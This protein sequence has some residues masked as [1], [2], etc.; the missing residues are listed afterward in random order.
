MKMKGLLIYLLQIIFYVS[1][2]TVVYTKVSTTYKLYGD[3]SLNSTDDEDFDGYDAKSYF[4][5]E[6]INNPLNEDMENGEEY[7]GYF[8]NRITNF[9]NDYYSNNDMDSKDNGWYH[10]GY[11]NEKPYGRNVD[12]YHTSIRINGHYQNSYFDKQ[13]DNLLNN[14]DAMSENDDEYDKQYNALPD[15]HVD[16]SH[17]ENFDDHYNNWPNNDY[18]EGRNNYHYPNY[19]YENN[20][21]HWHEENIGYGPYSHT[22]GNEYANED[23]GRDSYSDY[24]SNLYGKY[25]ANRGYDDNGNYHGVHRNDDHYNYFKDFDKHF[26]DDYHNKYPKRNYQYFNDRRR[27]NHNYNNYQHDNYRHHPQQNNYYTDWRYGLEDN[28]NYY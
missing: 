28:N 24:S 12:N 23:Y 9:N 21:N 20:A 11:N 16:Y 3:P 1:G 5:Y 26:Q 22:L 27:D 17:D 14:R 18:Y 7:Y 10:Y 19:N 6:E 15:N 2:R 13:P 8:K 4:P 25:E